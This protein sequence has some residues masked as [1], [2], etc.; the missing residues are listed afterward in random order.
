MKPNNNSKMRT[1]TFLTSIRL[2]L[3]HR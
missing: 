1:K 3:S 2:S